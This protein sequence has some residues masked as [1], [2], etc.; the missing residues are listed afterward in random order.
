MKY[1]IYKVGGII[2]KDK[3]L[4]ISR[5]KNKDFFIAPGGKIEKNETS[6]GALIRELKEELSIIV[7]ENQLREFDTFYAPA[8]GNES[9]ILRM[10]VFV[11]QDWEGEIIPA[12]EIEEIQWVDS[13]FSK[14][15]KIGS[16]FKHEVI[17][18]L[19]SLK[20]IK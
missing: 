18:K 16:I 13:D 19:K 4:L 7:Q 15:I 2:L 14:E 3:K 8:A 20:M 10:D 11:V 17:P 1:D 6:K 12:N 5:S 9:N